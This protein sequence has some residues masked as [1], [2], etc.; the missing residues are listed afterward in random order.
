MR[1]QLQRFYIDCPDWRLKVD[2]RGL[3]TVEQEISPQLEAVARRAATIDDLV[4]GL[5]AFADRSGLVAVFGTE[6]Q[7]DGAGL[8]IEVGLAPVVAAAA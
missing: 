5:R 2:V 1:H 4:R 8:E 3:V 6:P 7:W